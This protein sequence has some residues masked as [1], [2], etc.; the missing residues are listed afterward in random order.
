MTFLV[1]A[2]LLSILAVLIAIFPLMMRRWNSLGADQKAQNIALYRERE[3]E[4]LR[5]QAAQRISAEQ[6]EE[7]KTELARSLLIDADTPNAP[8]LTIQGNKHWLTSILV[9]MFVVLGAFMLYQRWGFSEQVAAWS[10][11]N[12]QVP[13]K[14][15][16]AQMARGVAAGLQKFLDKHPD[17]VNAWFLLTQVHM[18]AELYRE[19]LSAFKRLHALTGDDPSVLSQ[20]AQAQFLYMGGKLDPLGQ[21]L[22][23]KLLALEPQHPGGLNLRAV[24]AY[25]KQDY[26]TAIRDWRTVLA[27]TQEGTTDYDTV[28]GWVTV[29]YDKLL[30]ADPAA[31]KAL[32]AE[33]HAAT[34]PPS[35]SMSSA[36]AVPSS[37]G[38]IKVRVT[39][40]ETLKADVPADATLFV[41][42]R[43]PS[44]PPMPIAVEK[45]PVSALP[46]D[47][48][49]DDADAMMS[50]LKL[51]AQPVVVVGARISRSG[52]P[53]AQPGDWEA[54]LQRVEQPATGELPLVELQISAQV[55]AP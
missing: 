28:L 53:V 11:V 21:S 17:D 40:A 23:D 43:A 25:K 45:H 42:A 38:G 4:L 54:A 29:A 18:A 5:D 55:A 26:A 30:E 33:A 32:V 44:G 24:D 36:A 10:F 47:L 34:A 27:N 52:Q 46:L 3:A 31:A 9:A 14:V 8:L 20:Y 2:F 6:A 22:V 48:V 37:G 12:T 1:I 7:L 39:L 49:L 13:G 19:A 51:S 35:A 50:E 16:D 15:A 41:F